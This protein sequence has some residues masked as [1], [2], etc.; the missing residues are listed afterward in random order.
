MRVTLLLLCYLRIINTCTRV[1]VFNHVCL[2]ICYMNYA[3]SSDQNNLTSASTMSVQY[4][5]I[6]FDKGFIPEKTIFVAST[7]MYRQCLNS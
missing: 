7:S 1:I 4:S 6:I 3:S 5:P 2:C